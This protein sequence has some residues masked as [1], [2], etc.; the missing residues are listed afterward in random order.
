MRRFAERRRAKGEH[1][2][3]ESIWLSNITA[4]VEVEGTV[5]SGVFGACWGPDGS[6]LA[7]VTG[8]ST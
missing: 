6:L 7:L 5:E 2:C 1:N 8:T 3:R 4:Q